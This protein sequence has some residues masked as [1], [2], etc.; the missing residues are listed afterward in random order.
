MRSCKD[1]IAE[2]VE[3]ARAGEMPDSLL[4][5]HLAGCEACEARWQAEVALS[6]EFRAMRARAKVSDRASQTRRDVRAAALFEKIQAP[7]RMEPP[8]MPSRVLPQN[9]VLA[10][11][12]GLLLAVGIGY[13]LGA[14]KHLKPAAIGEVIYEASAAVYDPAVDM[15]GGEFITLPYA[16]P[17]APGEMVSVIHSDFDP[18]VLANLGIDVDPSWQNDDSDDIA[19][20]VV[21]GQDGL[22]RAVRIDSAD[23]TQF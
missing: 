23:R 7:R 5:A 17:L 12:A 2:L 10:A 13:G 16:L 3:Q 20:D 21:L 19:A 9:W 22:P 15:A 8:R 4:A 6:A 1:Y 18:S 11:A 14:R